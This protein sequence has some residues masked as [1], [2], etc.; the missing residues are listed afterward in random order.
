MPSS[1]KR[2]NFGKKGWKIELSIVKLFFSKVELFEFNDFWVAFF[3]EIFY[4]PGGTFRN[5]L[6]SY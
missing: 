3:V 4:M 5:L 2:L 1:L 6:L